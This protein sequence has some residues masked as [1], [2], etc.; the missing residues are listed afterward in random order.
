MRFSIDRSLPIALGVQ[1]RGLIEYGVACGE[2]GPGEQLPS[3]R[4][5][6]AALGVAPMTVAQVYKDLHAAGVI[7]T[8]AGRG[9]F[10]D[11]RAAVEHPI[12]R[13]RRRLNG[14]VEEAA[15]LGI[16]RRELVALLQ[17]SAGEANRRETRPGNRSLSIIFVGLFDEATAAYVEAI[18]NDLPDGERIAAT[19]IARIAADPVA[20]AGVRAADL[21]LTFTNRAVELRT[22]LGEH[23]APVMALRF[24]PSET[25]RRALA[26]LDP[27]CRVGL[28]ST[29]PEFLPIMKAGVGRF[30]PHITAPSATVLDD[31]ALDDFLAKC[32]VAVIATG[33]EAALRKLPPQLHPILYRHIPDPRDVDRLVLPAIDRLRRQA[34]GSALHLLETA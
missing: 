19:T 7:R 23:A 14:L 1:L 5:L 31:P 3:V 16:G 17:N 15:A 24:I 33:A 22:L 12:G 20:L 28:V 10:V 2:L 27:R 6:A 21:V 18:R 29:F 9:T 30:A 11:D 25:T 8:E 34:R 26:E 13:F 4:G 32:D